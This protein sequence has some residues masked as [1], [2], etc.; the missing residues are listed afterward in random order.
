MLSIWSQPSGYSFGTIQEQVTAYIDLPIVH[1]TPNNV[2]FKV[3]SGALPDGLR[4]AGTQLVGSPFVVSSL[5]TF[6]FCI[7]ASNGV[8]FADRTFSISVNG[9]NPPTFITPAGDLAIGPSQQ[10]YALDSSY[11]TFQ[12]EAFSLNSLSGNPLKF[13]I[14]SGDGTL[15]PGLSLSD[16]GLISGFVE[17]TVAMA[18]DTGVIITPA[19]TDGF[20]TYQYDDVFFDFNKP[21]L[22]PV[23]LNANYQFRVTISDGVSFSQR[24]FKIYVVGTDEFRADS[25]VQYGNTNSFTADST[26]IR[27]PVWITNSN[28]GLFRAN[29][30]F[31]V[32]VALYD[33]TYTMFRVE[34]TNMEVYA[35][36]TRLSNSQGTLAVMVAVESGTVSVGDTFT[37]RDYVDGASTQIYTIAGVDEI[38][39]GIYLLSLTRPLGISIPNNAPFFVGTAAVRSV[40][41]QVYVNDVNS[42]LVL[43]TNVVGTIKIGQYFTLD[44]YV[45]SASED[46][47]QINRIIDLGQ[48]I[49]LLG[50]STPLAVAIP[51][52]TTIYIGSLS[53]LPTGTMFD[54][55]TGEVYG[56]IPYQQTVLKTFNF[57]I[58][59][60]RLDPANIAES[61]SS[62]RTFTVDILGDTS[63]EVVWKTAPDLG[64]IPAN[65]VCTLSVEAASSVAGALVTYQLADDS[66]PLPPG[67][68]LNGDGE[69]L[70]IPNQF[71]DPE[72]DSLGIVRFYDDLIE[73]TNATGSFHVDD[74]LTCGNKSLQVVSIDTNKIYLSLIHI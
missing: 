62:S 31:T 42:R 71:Y 16:S 69:I 21:L 13:F 47:Y 34:A 51:S 58:T 33:N 43:V 25:T 63:S 40:S 38:T 37:L 14:A 23:V 44:N 22:T 15:P 12:L 48:G 5:T 64:T 26:Y 66:G 53:V 9:F 35:V 74:V 28:L 65:F 7:R 46:M 39:T 60:T 11:V 30:Y 70:G 73:Y 18:N 32:P 17:P 3:I 55:N 41:S 59:A 36:A 6:T 24:I 4:I 56:P 67:L 68:T 1:P 50:I 52:T 29:N 27:K 49:I 61:I 54:V 2:T 8:D 72:T 20:D 57:T 45:N 19:P 10:F